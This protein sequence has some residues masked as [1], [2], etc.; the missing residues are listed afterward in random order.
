MAGVGN[1]RENMDIH[2][3]LLSGPVTD[4]L[5]DELRAVRLDIL[6]NNIVRIPGKMMHVHATRQPIPE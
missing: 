4:E 5:L 1:Q 6:W 3:R 2:Y